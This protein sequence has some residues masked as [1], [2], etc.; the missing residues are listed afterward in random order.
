MFN[1]KK[2][3]GGFKIRT[4]FPILDASESRHIHDS[5]LVEII[6]KRI[7]ASAIHLNTEDLVA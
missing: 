6:D 5:I 3:H 2:N 7:N 1:L 4:P